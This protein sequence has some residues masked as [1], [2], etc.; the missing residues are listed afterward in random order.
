MTTRVIHYGVDDC[1]RL[2]VLRG[3]GYAVEDCSSL[4]EL[5]AALSQNRDAEAVLISEMEG[6]VPEDAAALAKC[7]S[8]A[9]LVLFRISNGFCRE[10]KF[11]LI[12]EALASPQQ[13]VSD[14]NALIQ[15]SRTLDAS[16][17]SVAANPLP[18][19]HAA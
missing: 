19:I 12:V 5:R 9:P 2:T 8:Q 13:W 16:S 4:A 17:Q 18:R 11:D 6:D 3:I 7:S 10:E 14:V 15:R 1:H